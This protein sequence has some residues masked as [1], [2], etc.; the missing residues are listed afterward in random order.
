[1]RR[2]STITRLLWSKADTVELLDKGQTRL[3]SII[4]VV[5]L[6][7]T[8]LLFA[9][10]GQVQAL[11][12]GDIPSALGLLAYLFGGAALSGILAGAIERKPPIP[13]ACSAAAVA[14]AAMAPH[15]AAAKDRVSRI[16]RAVLKAARRTPQTLKLSRVTLL[17]RRLHSSHRASLHR[18]TP[19][20]HPLVIYQ[21]SS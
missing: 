4:I 5:F 3:A 12:D 6:M 20:T 7:V 9:P 2:L 13:A 16:G 17:H 10:D 21:H 1:M 8:G 15:L 11:A 18:W 14:F 19:G